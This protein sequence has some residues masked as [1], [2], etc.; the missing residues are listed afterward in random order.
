[1]IDT[2]FNQK[3]KAANLA[4]YETFNLNKD[5]YTLLTLHRPSNVDYENILN[6]MLDEVIKIAQQY[7]VIFP[8]HPRTKQKLKQFNKL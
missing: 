4:Y 6:P 1:M 8:V 2:L 3:E 5:N 7:K